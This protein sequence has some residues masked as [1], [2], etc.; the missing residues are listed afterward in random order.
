VGGRDISALRFGSDFLLPDFNMQL[1]YD[2]RS[3]VDGA[4]GRV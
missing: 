1:P 3:S 2:A 4:A